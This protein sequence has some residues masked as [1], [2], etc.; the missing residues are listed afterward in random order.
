[1]ITGSTVCCNWCGVFLGNATSITYLNGN[2]ACCDLCIMKANA[3]KKS[4]I[5]CWCGGAHTSDEH[6]MIIGGL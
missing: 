5:P 1:M 4:I 2:M 6:P 3:V